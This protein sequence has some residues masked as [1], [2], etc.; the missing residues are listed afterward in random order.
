MTRSA[1]QTAP[2][3]TRIVTTGFATLAAAARGD[4][5]TGATWFARTGTATGTG[6][7]MQTARIE[8]IVIWGIK[9]L[10][11]GTDARTLAATTFGMTAGRTRFLLLLL[12]K[13]LN[14]GANAITFAA[15]TAARIHT[16]ASWFAGAGSTAAMLRTTRPQSSGIVFHGARGSQTRSPLLF[17]GTAAAARAMQTHTQRTTRVGF[18]NRTA[19]TGTETGSSLLSI[20]AGTT[21]AMQTR[22][23]SILVLSWTA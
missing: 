16:G 21:G 20:V 3:Q 8:T 22:T 5:Q 18:G 11:A 6:R 1:V 13:F 12:M 14:T 23:Q 15:T 10:N 17:A 7:S 4:T 19:A 9:V 2:V